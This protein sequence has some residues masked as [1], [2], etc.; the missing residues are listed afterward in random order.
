MFTT[1]RNQRNDVTTTVTRTEY[2]SDFLKPFLEPTT[3]IMITCTTIERKQLLNNY[4]LGQ[5]TK[6]LKKAGQNLN[7]LQFAFLLWCRG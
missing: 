6:I 1:K 5:I 2:R 3:V 7:S 4:E